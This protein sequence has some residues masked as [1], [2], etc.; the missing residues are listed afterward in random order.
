MNAYTENRVGLLGGTFNPIHLGHLGLAVNAKERFQLKSVY[1]IPAFISPNKREI[2]GTNHKHRTNMIRLALEDNPNFEL[3]E[4]EI[5]RGGISYTID[6]LKTLQTSDPHAK[7]FFL[8]G[9]DAFLDFGSWKSWRQILE[10]SNILVATRPDVEMPQPEEA[11]KIL[12]KGSDYNEL[13]RLVGLDF[14]TSQTLNI[15]EGPLFSVGAGGDKAL[16]L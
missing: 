8:L 9:M 6:T 15:E 3:C 14:R 5:N 12:F 13:G 1:F 10:R 2:T 7:Y 4:L 16:N 11:L